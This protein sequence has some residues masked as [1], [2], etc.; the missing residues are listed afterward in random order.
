MK[1]F[2]KALIYL[3]TVLT[4]YLLAQT[5]LQS[6]DD[7]IVKNDT[8]L[9]DSNEICKSI[10]AKLLLVQKDSSSCDSDETSKPKLKKI[11][12]LLCV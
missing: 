4:S 3:V 9:C 11:K 5:V 2:R 12:K 7:S 8:S 10:P 1:H 6:Q